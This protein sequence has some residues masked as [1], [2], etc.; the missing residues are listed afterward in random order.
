MSRR[1][2]GREPPGPSGHWLWG[3]RPEQKRDPLGLMMRNLRE[4][5]DVVGFRLG[6]LRALQLN[7]PDH[8]KHVLVDNAQGYVKWRAIQRIEPFLGQG[9]LLSEGDVWKRQRRL[10]QPAFRRDHLAAL[11]S[12][13]TGAITDLLARLEPLPDGALL[14]VSG[15]MMRL[16]LSIVGRVLF[17]IEVGDQAVELGRAFNVALE[18]VS[19]R[20][21]SFNPLGDLLPTRDNRRFRWAMRLL[22]GLVFELIRQR[23]DNPG[24]HRDL[25][26]ILLEIGIRRPARR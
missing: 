24:V 11:A 14:D 22:N 23:R 21:L 2:P 6:P 26:S 1:A 9:L 18:G 20:L 10:M 3:S 16:V 17:S 19:K 13:M 7:H 25:L 4:H 12:E 5:G 8:V 15:E